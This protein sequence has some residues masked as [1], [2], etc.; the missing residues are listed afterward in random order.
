MRSETYNC[1]NKCKKE[2]YKKS[3]AMKL[4]EKEPGRVGWSL[5]GTATEFIITMII[6]AL[7]WQLVLWILQ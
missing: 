4:R 1:D 6:F 2:I 7:L 3:L 5:T